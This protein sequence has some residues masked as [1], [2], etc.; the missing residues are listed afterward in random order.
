MELLPSLRN[1]N[2]K[3]DGIIMKEFSVK[4][5]KEIIGFLDKKGVND[6]CPVCDGVKFA[7]LGLYFNQRG[8][9]DLNLIINDTGYNI[10]YFTAACVNCGYMRN[11]A[12][13][14]QENIKNDISIIVNRESNLTSFV[15]F[16]HRLICPFRNKNKWKY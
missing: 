15:K 13:G 5:N 1:N 14:S 6:S 7:I 2:K 16:I 8:N 4:K 11:H 12:V 3:Q 10:S 9:K